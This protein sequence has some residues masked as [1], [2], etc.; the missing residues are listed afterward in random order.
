MSSSEIKVNE[1]LL[2][3]D[4][5]EPWM[6]KYRDI[7]AASLDHFE[8]DKNC[9]GELTVLVN[10]HP[11]LNPDPK[12]MKWIVVCKAHLDKYTKRYMWIVYD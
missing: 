8:P 4:G 11:H 9:N 2:C 7:C 10:T 3:L 1:V 6:E 5:Y 12:A